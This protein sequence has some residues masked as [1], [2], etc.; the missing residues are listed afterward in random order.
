MERTR[1]AN[2]THR[3]ISCGRLSTPVN[4]LLNQRSGIHFVSLKMLYKMIVNALSPPYLDYRLQQIGFVSLADLCFFDCFVGA[5]AK[6]LAT[7]FS[8]CEGFVTLGDS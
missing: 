5:K 7:P 8:P 6:K 1:T 2:S 4:H 3:T